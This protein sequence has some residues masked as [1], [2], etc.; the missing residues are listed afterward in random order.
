MDIWASIASKLKNNLTTILLY[1]VYSR[2]SSPGRKGF[3]MAVNS[4]G[5]FHGTIGGGI[6][7]VKLVEL[8]KSMLAK[9]SLTPIIK[10]QYHDKEKGINKSGMICSGQQ[11]VA[12]IPLMGKDYKLINSIKNKK[13]DISIKISPKGLEIIP[14]INK[15]EYHFENT[16]E[17]NFITPI[18][19][20]R[21]IHIFGAG[22]VGVALSQQMAL[23]NYD[24]ILYD[25]RPHLF[26]QASLSGAHNIIV[27]DYN[28]LKNKIV[29][30]NQDVAAIVSFGYRSDKVILKNIYKMPF[31]YIGM[32][33]SDSK[34]KVLIEEL[35]SE[36]ISN[37][38][39]SHIFTPIGLN[40]YSK[41]AQEIAVSIAAQIILE[42]NKH[43][44]HGRN[45]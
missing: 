36:G 41:S 37:E 42:R 27:T 20:T 22:H 2:G 7:E 31:K 12:L 3:I 32:M 33:G 9:Q 16:H 30:K 15:Q 34:I 23:L 25:D 6:M 35:N 14:F 24:I 1:V 39:I 18:F 44:P 8:A 38:D 26:K 21:R 43:L 11:D 29:L 28:E 13:K 40:I 10:K 19:S 17:F 45:Y 5:S 4:D